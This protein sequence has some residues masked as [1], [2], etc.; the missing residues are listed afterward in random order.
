LGLQPLRA[1]PPERFYVWTGEG[2]ELGEG[3]G[4][5]VEPEPRLQKFASLAVKVIIQIRRVNRLRIFLALKISAVYVL[6]YSSRRKQRNY[7]ASSTAY[8]G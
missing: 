3:E 2:L 7:G 4:L 8:S 5:V 6:R 1:V